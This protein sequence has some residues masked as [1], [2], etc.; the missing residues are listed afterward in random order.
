MKNLL[1]Y[2][3]RTMQKKKKYFLT[4][5]LYV[6]LFL[7][8]SCKHPEKQFNWALSFPPSYRGVKGFAQTQMTHC[9]LKAEFFHPLTPNEYDQSHLYP[10]LNHLCSCFKIAMHSE[11]DRA[12][13]MDDCVLNA[14]WVCMWS[15]SAPDSCRVTPWPDGHYS[16]WWMGDREKGALGRKRE[17]GGDWNKWGL[18]GKNRQCIRVEWARKHMGTE[19]TE[20][21]GASGGWSVKVSWGEVKGKRRG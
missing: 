2:R 16:V 12:M 19:V 8:L 15:V 10:H 17:G 6:L 11:L 14:K 4:Q 13:Q 18:K 7:W 20:E 1:G 21:R 9:D 3:R 5:S